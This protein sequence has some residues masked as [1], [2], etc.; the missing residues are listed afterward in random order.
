[1]KK[2]YILDAPYIDP[3]SLNSKV[4]FPYCKLFLLGVKKAC[5]MLSLVPSLGIYRQFIINTSNN[6][7]NNNN[8]NRREGSTTA[9]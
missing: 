6:N 3:D 2:T 7:N 5:R 4:S 8:N 1:M 9:W